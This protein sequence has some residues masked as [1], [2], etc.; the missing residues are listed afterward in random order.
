MK[1]YDL[2]PTYENLLET[3]R[4][5][6]IDRNIDI[7]RFVS[8]LDS[9]D[10]ACAIAV[11]GNWGSGKTFF[12]KQVK[13][14]MD[15]HN[16]FVCSETDDNRSEIM[17]IRERY[18]GKNLVPLQPQICV[19]YDSWENDNDS[20]PVMSLV[21]TILNS[22]DSDFSLKDTNFLEI[23]ASI[24]ELFSGKDWMKVIEKLRG[25]S[26]LDVI[27]ENK[28]IK[29]LVDD[30]LDA[31][32][33]EKGERLVIFIDEL[34]RCKPSYAVR[35][36]ERIKHYFDHDRITFVF[37]VNT[38]ELHH[39]VK[40]HYGNDFDGSRYLDRFFDLRISLPPPNLEKFYQSLNFNNTN[41]IYDFVCDAVI[42][43][44]HFELREI[45]KFL[46]LTKIAAYNATHGNHEAYFPNERALQFCMLYILPVMIGLRVSDTEKYSNFINGKDHSS[47]VEI[48]EN[49]KPL[50]IFNSLLNDQESYDKK[51]TQKEY[52]TVPGKLKAVYEAI[53]TVNYDGLTYHT[54]I[55]KMEFSAKTKRT[56]LQTA[57]LLSPHMNTNII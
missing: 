33:P 7:F 15:A 18:L 2:K 27:R 49:A 21:Y 11:D 5:D 26:P 44:Y 31:L 24:I 47:L 23:G 36:L 17:S 45:A 50:H 35:L 4:K 13:M 43:T 9:I 16:E 12:V 25:S 46:R 57:G 39:T 22:V 56:L 55:G 20:D 42:K 6:T 37:S 28:D 8:I 30:F 19:Y 40:K 32:L 41:Y 54:I 53:F 48:A 14:V 52:V 51:E 29:K 1:A 34:D 38:N 10:D 3:Y